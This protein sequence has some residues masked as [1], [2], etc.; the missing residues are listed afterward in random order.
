MDK[1]FILQAIRLSKI[2]LGQ[3]APNPCVA[4]IIVKDAEIIATGVTQKN[5]RPHAETVAIEKAA[6]EKLRGAT[7]YVTLEPCC[8]HGKTAPCTDLIIASGIK[9]VVIA[10]QDV[11]VRVNGG[12]IKKLREAGIDVLCGVY[13]NEAREINKGFFKAKISGL[14]YITLKL[15][16][17]LDGKIATKNHDSKWITSSQARVFAHHL[18]SINNAIMV[19]ANTVKRDDPTLDCRI[20]GLS[21]SSPKRIIVT[22]KLDFLGK[23]KIFQ[24]LQQ[25]P[26][27][28]LTSK[29]NAS[30]VDNLKKLGVEFIFCEEKNGYVDLKDALQ[31]LCE[32]GINSVLIEGG[33]ILATQLLQENLVDEIVWIQNKKIIGSDGISAVGELGFSKIDE[34]LQNFKRID[35]RELSEEDFVSIYKKVNHPASLRA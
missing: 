30:Q 2:T 16:T 1:K 20:D 7:L 6:K 23:E 12:G 11:D 15:A 24:N 18:R 32:N 13:E 3:T 19:G 10:T 9:K 4:C 33:K 31:K 14:P 34:A 21:D 28:I 26:T 5:G 35:L 27:I 29:N 8:H 22:N 25:I 17:S